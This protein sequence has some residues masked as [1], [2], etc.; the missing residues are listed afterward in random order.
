M[1]PQEEESNRERN[2]GEVEA[3]VIG[4]GDQPEV[5]N[6]RCRNCEFSSTPCA[7]IF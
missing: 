5:K 7:H 1:D 2:R 4:F 6:S 3:L